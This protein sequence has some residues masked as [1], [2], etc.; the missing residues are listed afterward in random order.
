M[1]KSSYIVLSLYKFFEIKKIF[2]FKNNIN[3]I[4]SGIDVK[5]II[6]IAP[7]GININIS[8]KEAAYEAIE[9][10]LKK[11]FNYQ[12]EDIKKNKEE[13]HIFRK[14]KIK[15]KKEILTTRNVK[16][17]NPLNQVGKYVEADKWNSFISDTNT[18]LIDMRNNY[19]V[20]IGTFNQAINPKCE[21]FTE[22]LNWLKN[23]FMNIKNIDNK[24]IAMFCTGGIRCEKATSFLLNLGKKNVYH[25]KGGILKYLEKQNNN[26]N[27]KNL[28]KGECFVFDNRVSLDTNLK[29]GSYS[30]C[31]ACRMPLTNADKNREEYI[32]GE[33]CH[34]CYSIKTEEQRKRYRMRN[35][36]IKLRN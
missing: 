8:I 18:L 16:D 10:K 34:L 5:G 13:K 33:A 20:E 24:K 21:N 6:L 19:E 27:N 2:N 4:F 11:I 1:S 26:S 7:E 25:L 3:K 9:K 14:F 23:D 36:Q 17:T 32:E 29:K 35:N 22:L 12:D 15:I 31:H 30:L 28:W